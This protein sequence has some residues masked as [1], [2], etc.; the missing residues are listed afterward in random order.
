MG[1]VLHALD[2]SRRLAQLALKLNRREQDHAILLLFKRASE[3]PHR[4]G[5]SRA[6]LARDDQSTPASLRH[7]VQNTLERVR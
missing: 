5:L 2:V 6:T 3:S 7:P 4:R 1:Q